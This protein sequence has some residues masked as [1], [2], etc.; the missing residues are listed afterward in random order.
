MSLATGERSPAVH[1][2]RIRGTLALDTYAALPTVRFDVQYRY[3]GRVLEQLATHGIQPRPTT[4]PE[5]VREFLNDL[6]CYELRR[7]RDRLRRGE[8]P[9]D[10]YLDRVIELRLKYPLLSL[11]PHQL[12]E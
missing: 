12:V 7:L 8:I 5:L 2:R 1:Q 6:Y 11:K 10:G 3:W 4:R 9:K